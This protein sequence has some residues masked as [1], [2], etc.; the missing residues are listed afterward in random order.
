MR[1]SSL[2]LLLLCMALPV[3]ATVPGDMKITITGT[4]NNLPRDAADNAFCSQNLSVSAIRHRLRTYRPITQ[5]DVHDSYLWLD[6]GQR[7]LLTIAGRTYTWKSYVTRVVETTYP[8]GR[9]HLLGGTPDGELA[10]AN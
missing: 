1:G 3:P 5:R 10:G 8:D 7:G 9:P 2:G 4:F 6:C